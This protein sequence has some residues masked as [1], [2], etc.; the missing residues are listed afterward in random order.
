MGVHT[1]AATEAGIDTPGSALGIGFM[2]KE[3]FLRWRRG[4]YRRPQRSLVKGCR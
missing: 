4:F 3:G 2:L 1:A